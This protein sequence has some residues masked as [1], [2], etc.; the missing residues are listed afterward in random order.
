MLHVGLTS[1]R[2]INET[3][4]AELPTP[5]HT[6]LSRDT[7]VVEGWI[8]F[9][10]QGILY[11]YLLVQLVANE[12]EGGSGTLMER[13][14]QEIE[15]MNAQR[16]NDLPPEE[17]SMR[18]NILRD[19]YFWGQCQAGSSIVLKE[20]AQVLFYPFLQVLIRGGHVVKKFGNAR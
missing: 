15:V 8:D 10:F 14:Y 17:A 6:F 7:I 20:G 11:F 12:R 1:L 19:D 16:Q 9:T 18:M 3:R 2:Y 5:P 13:A 4:L